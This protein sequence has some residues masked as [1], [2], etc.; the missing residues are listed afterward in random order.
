MTSLQIVRV[1]EGF[2]SSAQK[3]IYSYINRVLNQ[4]IFLLISAYQYCHV[5][6]LRSDFPY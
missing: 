3:M 2:M 5:L 6:L 4:E 1:H